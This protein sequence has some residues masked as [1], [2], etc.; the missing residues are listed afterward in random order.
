APIPPGD[1]TMDD[2]YNII[3][4]NPP[5][6]ICDIKGEQLWQMMEDNLE[7]TFS[8]DPYRQ[9]GGYVKRCLGL[10]IYFKIENPYR[11][12]ILDF[13]IEGH[14]LNPAKMYRACFLTIQGI[15]AHYGTNRRDLKVTAIDALKQ[16]FSKHSP[17]SST[18]K[19][20]IIPI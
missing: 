8:R 18:L 20:T 2:L 4:H 3:P 12:R 16:Y 6:P 13:F 9:Q 7:N 11:K 1:V 5:I 14:P 15:P 10:N 17:V 19:G